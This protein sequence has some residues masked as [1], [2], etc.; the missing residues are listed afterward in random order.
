MRSPPTATTRLMKFVSERCLVGVGHELVSACWTPQALDVGALRR[1]EH[2][3]VAA[4]RSRVKCLLSRSTSTRWPI[5]SVG[6]IDSLGMRNGL[7]RNAWIPSARPSA[8]ATIVT[9]SMSE[10]PAPFFFSVRAG[11]RLGRSRGDT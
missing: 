7:T 6:T 3:D 4:A 11:L 5:W 1:L 2:E 8:T 10:P 9:S